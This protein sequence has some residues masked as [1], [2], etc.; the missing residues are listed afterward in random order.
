[1]HRPDGVFAIIFKKIDTFVGAL[2][3]RL[4]GYDERRKE[5]NEITHDNQWVKRL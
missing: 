5:V 1:M 4:R 3:T 2:D